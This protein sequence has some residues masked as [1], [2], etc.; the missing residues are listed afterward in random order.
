VNQKHKALVLGAVIA[1]A[2]LP[3]RV[4]ATNASRNVNQSSTEGILIRDVA[5]DMVLLEPDTTPLLV[6]TTNSKRKTGCKAPKFEW[7]EDSEVSFWTQANAGADIAAGAVSVP[8]LDITLFAVGDIVAVPKA[9]ASTA[10]EEIM[11]VTA[12]AGTTTGTITV[13]RGLGGGADTITATGSLRIIGGAFLENDALPV[14][15]YT[16]KSTVASYAQIF[17]TTVDISETER[18]TEIYGAPEGE[19]KYQIAKAMIR[20][21]AEI[22]AAGWWSRASETAAAQSRWTTMRLQIP[23]NDQ[24]H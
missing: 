21:K 7:V 17:R 8:V 22:E 4:F 11:L 19:E 6:L 12:L 18:A 23:R 10:A 13:T 24:R 2:M 16:T 20:H 3:P 1:V 15:R 9:N 14:G 5:N